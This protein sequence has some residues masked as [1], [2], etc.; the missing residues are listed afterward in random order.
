MSVNFLWCGAPTS[1]SL[2]PIVVLTAAATSVRVA[3]SV[4]ADLSSPIWSATTTPDSLFAC[5]PGSVTGL[6]P[7]TRYYYA[8]EVDGVLDTVNV[9]RARTLPS[10]SSPLRITFGSCWAATGQQYHG[11]ENH[12]VGTA[13]ANQHDAGAN[14]HLFAGDMGYLDDQ[15]ND[16]NPWADNFPKLHAMPHFSKMARSCAWDSVWDDHDFGGNDS[17]STFANKALTASSWR[18]F[19]PNYDLPVTDAIYHAFNITPDVRV[20][21]SD[22]RYFRDPD[23]TA[24][25]TTKTMMGATQKAWLKAQ[26]LAAKN[27]G[28]LIIW[29]TSSM[30]CIDGVYG[31]I[32]TNTDGDGWWKFTY[33]RAELDNFRADNGI[34]DMVI[35]TG[36][37]HQISYRGRCD[38]STAQTVPVPT[39][40][41]AAYSRRPAYREGA[42]DRTSTPMEA[43]GHYGLLTINPLPLRGWSIHCEFHRVDVV[44]GEDRVQFATETAFKGVPSVLKSTGTGSNLIN[45]GSVT[46]LISP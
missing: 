3:F 21:V 27:A 4:N 16:P 25:S 19:V 1:T 32:G 22:L 12:P 11:V 5:R 37:G 39:Y 26:W 6:T 44:T 42:W 38:Y 46:N 24:D 41:A 34:T 9:A 15:I 29:V 13:V 28:Q 18:Q 40:A 30:W 10:K 43:D 33:E 45:V 2:R 17:N 35:L 31:T 14:M 23:T 8:A 36:D 7:D 20:V